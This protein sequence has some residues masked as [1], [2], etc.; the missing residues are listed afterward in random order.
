[1]GMVI[2]MIFGPLT[3]AGNQ[4]MLQLELLMQADRIGLVDDELLHADNTESS[5]VGD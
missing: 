5:A 2:D 3:T 1:M 4:M